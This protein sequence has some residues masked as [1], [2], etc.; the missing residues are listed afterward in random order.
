M[1]YLED[2]KQFGFKSS[3]ALWARANQQTEEHLPS[4]RI[5]QK[6]HHWAKIKLPQNVI[7]WLQIPITMITLSASS[8]HTLLIPFQRKDF[9]GCRFYGFDFKRTYF[10]N[11]SGRVSSLAVLWQGRG[12][13]AGGTRDWLEFISEFSFVSFSACT[14]TILWTL[15][16]K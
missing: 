12:G 11:T 5:V 15:N 7:F 10:S 4:L 16:L 6:C 3:L 14:D 13:V 2:R 9:S 8:G 1:R